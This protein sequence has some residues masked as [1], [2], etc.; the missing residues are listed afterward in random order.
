[1]A[2]VQSS[3]GQTP[4]PVSTKEYQEIVELLK[5]QIKATEDQIQKTEEV[6][7]SIT[8][9]RIGNLK[10]KDYTDYLLQQSSSI[11]PSP[12][13]SYVG[14]RSHEFK[15]RPYVERL[16]TTVNSE[17]F[18]GLFLSLSMT[19]EFMYNI[20]NRRL[21]YN[22]IVDKIVSLQTFQD[23][24]KRFTQIT[25]FV[26]D[27]GTTKDLR[28]IFELQTRIRSMSAI[29]QNEYAKLQMVKNLSSNE[30][31]L[32]EIQKRKLY[33]KVISNAHTLVP[34]LRF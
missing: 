32:L 19:K 5:K 24:E 6:Y 13:K 23:A 11:Y 4:S 30:E 29:L 12:H 2:G 28:E 15:N 34:Q 25:N 26:N 27:I 7:Q 14:M 21:Q 8:G 16:M 31:L 18:R 33:E 10:I 20:V 9:N 1:G 3:A 22:A 17:E